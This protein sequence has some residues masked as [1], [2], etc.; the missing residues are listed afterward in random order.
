MLQNTMYDVVL[1]DLQMP[2][3]D[4]PECTRRF[5]VWEKTHREGKPRQLVIGMSANAEQEDI[6]TCRSCGMDGFC[7]KP[8]KLETLKEVVTDCFNNRFEEAQELELREQ[9]APSE[10]GNGHGEHKGS[11]PPAV[12]GE[13]DRNGSESPVVQR[14]EQQSGSELPVV[15]EEL[16]VNDS[17]ES[18][19][20]K[21][22]ACDSSDSSNGQYIFRVYRQ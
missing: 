2:V 11:D 10:S 7:P 14:G 4:G 5:R 22:A 16:E 18:S 12:Q 15:Q 21:A 6:E 8:V 1:C 17:N 9:P 20:E 19:E 3:M 13:E